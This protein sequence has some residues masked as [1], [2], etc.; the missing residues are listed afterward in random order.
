MIN[1]TPASRTGIFL[2]FFLNHSELASHTCQNVGGD[3]EKGEP[4]CTV[5]G[6]AKWYSHSGKQYGVS[7]KKLKTELPYDLGIT[8]LGVYLEDTGVLI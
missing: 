1:C 3:A 5:G 6:K 2:I 8:L 4:F 7:S